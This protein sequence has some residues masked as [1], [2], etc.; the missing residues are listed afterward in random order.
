MTCVERFELENYGNSELVSASLTMLLWALSVGGTMSLGLA[1]KTWFVLRM[2]RAAKA[3]GLR[4][5]ARVLPILNCFLW[6]EKLENEAWKCV[7]ADLQESIV[8]S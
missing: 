5:W 1:E 7:S 6:E 2:S 3:L 4:S 8:T